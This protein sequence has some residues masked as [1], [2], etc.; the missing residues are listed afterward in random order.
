MTS[1]IKNIGIYFSV[2]MVLAFLIGG[3]QAAII[4]CVLAIL[5]ISLSF[6][7][8]IVNAKE[9][10]HM[11]EK[12]RQRFLTWGMLIAVFG[13]RI[14]FPLLI[15]SVV[16]EISPWS[17]LNMAL[18]EPEQY[19]QEITSAHVSVMG[20]GGSF[21]FM[22]FLKFFLDGSKDVHWLDVIEHKL[23]QLGKIDMVE[24]YITL[25]LSVIVSLFLAS[26]DQHEGYSFLTSSV[27]GVVTYITVDVLRELLGTEDETTGMVVRTGLS[28]FIY[29]EVLDSSFSFDGVI[30]AFAITNNLLIIAIGLGIGAL[31]VRTMTIMLVEK[32][33]LSEFQYLE[34]SA[35]WAIGILATIM[36]INTFVQVS[37]IVTGLLGAVV[38]GMGLISSI[39]YKR[40][41]E[42][43]HLST[44][45]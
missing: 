8:A 43:E 12:W 23:M 11:D 40:K 37:E 6:D 13:M 39:I 30:G 15:V 31:A 14:L 41:E 7:N 32:G 5:E 24:V 22:V 17:A 21:L 3:I 26:H 44:Q 18:F 10:E 28:S 20:F 36:Y 25:V 33:T 9:L 27:L 34:H 35:F 4:T 2:G 1:Y 38:I 45:H 19:K 16:A 29:L 42:S